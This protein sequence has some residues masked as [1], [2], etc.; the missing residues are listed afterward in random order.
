[1]KQILSIL[2]SF[3]LLSSHVNLTLG[4]H[5]CGGD[6]VETKI[7]FGESHLGCGMM[8]KE[9]SCSDSE[10][11]NNDQV[12]FDKAPCCKNEFHT[13]QSTDDFVKD[14]AQ[15]VFNIDFAVAFLYTALN[16]DLLSKGTQQFYKE[17]ISPPLEKDIQVLFQT[18]L[19]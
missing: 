11:T 14:A 4:T 18:F 16:L 13:I 9:E 12:S 5:F 6:A 2:M 19:I 7:L 10:P 15:I 8:D 1:M 17:Y 3:I